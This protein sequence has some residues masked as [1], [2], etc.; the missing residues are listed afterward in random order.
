[1]AQVRIGIR[2]SQC[3]IAVR[4]CTTGTS[5]TVKRRILTV[6]HSIADTKPS[7]GRRPPRE[8]GT[9]CRSIARGVLG[10]TLIFHAEVR[11][12]TSTTCGRESCKEDAVMRTI[13]IQ[14]NEDSRSTER[15]PQS[16]RQTRL[17]THF[18]SPLLPLAMKHT[19]C[20]KWRTP[21]SV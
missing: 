13:V 19:P 7:S 21:C 15:A 11:S 6:T 20:E 12:S 10:S 1:M 9:L 14:V 2:R 16:V 17:H 3:P 5:S 4:S 8:R 18:L